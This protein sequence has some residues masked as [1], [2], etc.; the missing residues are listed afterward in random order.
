MFG[1]LWKLSATSKNNM[2]ILK[3]LTKSTTK[4][5]KRVGRGYGSGA[6]GHT[7][8]RGAKGDKIRGKTKITF[9]GTKIKKGWIKRTPFLRG[10]HRL[11]AQGQQYIFNFI[12]IEKMYQSGEVVDIQSLSKK[13]KI[14]DKLLLSNVKILSKGTLTK[15]LTFK[16]LRFSETAKKQIVALGGKIE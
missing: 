15:A 7:T 14:H 4:Q 9:D 5:K 1:Q 16:G 3:Q 12:D 10:K 2:E 13:S 11:L 8:G 6:G